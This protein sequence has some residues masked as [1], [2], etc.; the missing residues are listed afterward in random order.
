MYTSDPRELLKIWERGVHR[1]AV[2]RGLLLLQA[3]L[4]QADA[5]ALMQASI[6]HRDAWLLNLREALFGVAIE[7]LMPC[8]A[9]GQRIEVDFQVD[10]VRVRHAL[11]GQVCEVED[12]SRVLRFRLPTTADLLAIESE[13]DVASA[14]ARLLQRCRLGDEAEPTT[15]TALVPRA[16]DAVERAMGEADPQAEVLLALACPA[17]GHASL[18]AFDIATHLWLELDHWARG[19]LQ[20]VHALACRYG[21]R[22][23]DILNLSPARRQAYL[24]MTGGA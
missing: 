20:K 14:Q 7:C 18:Q 3:A 16:H 9:C 15:E 21:W 13:P 8:P 23:D 12:G 2:A 22:E 5:D 1:S 4:P 11:P 17:C 6:G 24:Q 10:D 19:M